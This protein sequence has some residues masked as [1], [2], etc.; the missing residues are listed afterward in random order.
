MEKKLDYKKDFKEFYLPRKIE[1]IDIPKMSFF[2]IDGVG[3]PNGEE[4]AQ[5]VGALYSLAYAIKMSPK[6]GTEPAGY[7][8]Y[9]VFPLEGVWDLTDLGKTMAELDKN[10]LVYRMMIRQPDFVTP[11]YAEQII[12]QVKKSKPNPK[13]DGVRFETVAE[14]LCAQMMHL[15]PYD[16]EPASFELMEAFC[17]QNGYK[18]LERKHREIYLSD[19][20]KV[21]P[22]KMR[23]VLRVKVQKE[24][25]R[26]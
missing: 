14:G 8:E 23:T 21:E 18:R 16:D 17:K 15:G 19:P 24:R 4:F 9:T 3:N 1:I 13:L 5:V 7:F 6:K 12:L 25:E 10:Q 2:T 11:A 22:Q 20:R 26:K